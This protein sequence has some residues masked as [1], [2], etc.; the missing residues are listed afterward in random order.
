LILDEIIE[1]KRAEVAWLRG[2]AA[3]LEAAAAAV[4][5][6]RGF[7]AALRAPAS[8]SVIAEFKRR[9]PS[10]GD[11]NPYAD[12]ADVARAYEQ[13]GATA[14]SVLTDGPYFGGELGD[15]RRAREASGLPLLRKDFII[16]PLQ[17]YESRAAG[18]DAV[19]LIVKALS[20]GTLRE[21]R[22]G[23]EDLGMSALVEAH[24]AA[25]VERALDAGARIVGVNARDL[26]T[27]DVDLDASLILIERIPGDVTAIAESGVRGGED[28]ARAG[29]AG[30]DAVLVGGW[31]MKSDPRRGVEELAGH[32]RRP[33]A[34][35]E[36]DPAA[37]SF[38][39]D[40]AEDVAWF[41]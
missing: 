36:S 23:A 8:V 31:L 27:F 35:R 24:D 16:D 2:A 38:D 39:G 30:A 37:T 5:P 40:E 28:V 18:A 12:I 21:L 10:E 15:L 13:G 7:D 19:L 4:D 34:G 17:L 14:L 11:I 26:Q 41:E 6:P 29:R 3:D 20:D 33:R 22:V 1:N 9:S 25:E 32:R